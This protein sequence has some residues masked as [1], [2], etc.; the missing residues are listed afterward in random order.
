[1]T[2][3]VGGVVEGTFLKFLSELGILMCFY[4]VIKVRNIL[5]PGG[6]GKGQPFS[7][8]WD[9]SYRQFCPILAEI[10]KNDEKRTAVIPSKIFFFW[11]KLIDT[12]RK[13]C[14]GIGKTLKMQKK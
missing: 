3:R 13:W 11:F 8:F 9:L 12:A 4:V 7:F 10:G 6:F 1:M 5:S 2:Q 14:L